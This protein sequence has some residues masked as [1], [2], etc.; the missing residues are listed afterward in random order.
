LLSRLTGRIPPEFSRLTSLGRPSPS[1]LNELT[2]LSPAF[3]TKSNRPSGV[4]LIDPDVSMIG[5]PNGGSDAIPIPPV[6]TV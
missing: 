4:R 1:I 3:T 2:V 5:N 6:L